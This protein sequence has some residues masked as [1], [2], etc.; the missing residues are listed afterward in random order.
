MPHS[1]LGPQLQGQ[2]HSSCCPSNL[3]IF[4]T[5]SLQA[6]K[7]AANL[8]RAGMSHYDLSNDF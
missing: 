7:Q 8:V 1:Q 6:R 4:I 3:W 2:C 5:Y